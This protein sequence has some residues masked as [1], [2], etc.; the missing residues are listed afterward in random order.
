[1]A[2]SVTGPPHGFRDL[3]FGE[4]ETRRRIEREFS[5]VFAAGGYREI[6]P[7]S[8]EMMDVYTRGNQSVGERTFRF[9]DRDDNLLALRGD[10]TPAIARIVAGSPDDFSFP[11]KGWYCGSVFRKADRNRGL[12][13]EFCQVG[14]EHIGV[15]TIAQDAALVDI[16][17]RG[18]ARA[19]VDDACVHVNHAGIFR[20]FVAALDLDEAARAKVKSTIDRKDMRTLGRKLAELGIGAGPRSQVDVLARCVGNAGV[21]ETA[22]GALNNRESD[23]ALGE[24]ATLAVLLSDWRDRVVFDLTEIDEMEYYTGCMFTFFSPSHSGELGKGGRYDGLLKEFGA[25]LPA[26]GFSLSVDRISECL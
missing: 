21:L 15:G 3:L 1:M 6:I 10:F 20:G 2:R 7:S 23:S 25:D 18:L 13:Q 14:A 5:A 19:G 8:V 11:V 16:A 26:V 24:L 17:L 4:A 12:F 9:L 22:A